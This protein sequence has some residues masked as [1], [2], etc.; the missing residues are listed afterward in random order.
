VPPK[1]I[2]TYFNK[3]I[4]PVIREQYNMA[5]R[6]YSQQ[7]YDAQVKRTKYA[8]SKYY[9]QMELRLNNAHTILNILATAN[10]PRVNGTIQRPAE[11]PAHITQEFLDM[12]IQLNKTYT[13]P[14]CYELV[15]KETIHITFC[16]H[17]LCKECLAQIVS[18]KK[19]PTCR[20][21]LS[22]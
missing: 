8:W 1:K 10:I 11:L 18:P 22:D 21:A 6:T 3:D 15:N 14:C 19:C 9:A 20:K 7:Q 16:G 4:P 12:A 17:I 13:C 2:E 5:T